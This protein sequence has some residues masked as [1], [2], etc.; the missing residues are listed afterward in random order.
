[1]HA[2]THVFGLLSLLATVNAAPAPM[3]TP[4]KC[5]P[6]PPGL[7]SFRVLA[8]SDNE[9]QPGIPTA[10]AAQTQ[11]AGLTVATQVDDGNYDRDLFPTWDTISG[12][13]NT[14]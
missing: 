8:M 9:S 2:P 14:R 5:P 13:C 11:L 12:A 6:P 3:P 10:S 1:M 7:L 4:V